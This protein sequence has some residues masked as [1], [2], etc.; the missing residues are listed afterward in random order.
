MWAPIPAPPPSSC[1]AW[2]SLAASLSASFLVCGRGHARVRLI[3][4]REDD[5]GKRSRRAQPS[6][7]RTSTTTAAQ[8]RQLSVFRRRITAT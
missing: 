8:K 1:M 5:T 6:A 3:C 4:R 7:R 2:A